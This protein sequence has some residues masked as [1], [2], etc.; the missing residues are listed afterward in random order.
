MIKPDYK[1]IT[2]AL[3]YIAKQNGGEI[4]YMKALKLLYFADRLHLRRYG[5]FITD[6]KLVAMKMGTLG[7]QAKDIIKQNTYL[8]HEV[9]LYIS[10]KLKRKL[11]Q[12]I[13][14]TNDSSLD[15]M[16]ETDLECVNEIL[17]AVGSYNELQLKDL[18]HEL[19]EWKRFKYSIESGEQTVVEINESDLFN[20]TENKTLEKIYSEPEDQLSLAHSIF[21]ETKEQKLALF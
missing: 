4:N 5:R 8:P 14:G 12:Y 7:S 11:D 2:Q 6:D 15:R 17:T 9:Y 20:K 3:N 18:T 1:K 10:D 21:S 19:P 16:S 13:I